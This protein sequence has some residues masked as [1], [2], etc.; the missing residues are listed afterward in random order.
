M[1]KPVVAAVVLVTCSLVLGATVFHGQIASAA[2]A[3]L[4]VLV[5]NDAAHAV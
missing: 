4:P 2:H 5:T 1:L 3:I